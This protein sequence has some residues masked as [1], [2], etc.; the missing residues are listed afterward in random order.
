MPKKGFTLIELLVV[1]TIIAL[2]AAVGLINY[3]KVSQS[4]RDAKRQSDLKQVQSALEQYFA[5]QFFYPSS[6][7]FNFSLSNLMGRNDNPSPPPTLKNYLNKV[8]CDPSTGECKNT[9][10]QY[11]YAA[12]PASCTN[13]GSVTSKCTNYEVYAALEN[14]PTPVTFY[15][16]C[17]T[18]NIYNLKVIRP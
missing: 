15:N 17:N 8:P 12:L 1:I 16:V 5:D 2:L 14:P 3:Q 7:Q 10:T 18:T 6:I 4:G 11:C 9:G 13:S